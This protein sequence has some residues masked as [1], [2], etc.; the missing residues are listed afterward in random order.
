MNE[1]PTPNFPGISAPTTDFLA[2]R[3]Q[4]RTP[5]LFVDVD[6]TSARAITANSQQ[7]LTI[8]G[9]FIYCDP[10]LSSGVATGY[11]VGLDGKAT[12]ITLYPGAAFDVPFTS[13]VIENT[14][15]P[16]SGL[17]LIYGTDIAFRPA[18]AAGVSILNAISVIDGGF[19]K[20]IAGQAFSAGVSQAASVGNLSHVQL[21][22]PVGSGVNAVLE[23][24][25]YTCN[26][27]QQVDLSRYDVAL[28][29][30]LGNAS[31]KYASTAGAVTPTSQCQL[32]T[33]ANAALLGIGNPFR[34]WFDLNAQRVP[35]EPL[36]KPIVLTP[37]TGVLFR[38]YTANIGLWAIFDFY[39]QTR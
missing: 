11:F 10:K 8:S 27:A 2:I 38:G 18:N 34:H 37:G 35:L 7:L 17:R 13:I 33:Q 15:Q 16:A 9:N 12:P 21:W 3:S 25:G 20:T 24:T 6:L 36:P 19:Q 30:N 1:Q 28:T 4:L 39:E 26:A 14:A 5:P 32:R 29:T 22:N 31:N 23:M